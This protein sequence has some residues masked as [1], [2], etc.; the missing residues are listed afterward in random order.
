MR[1]K[2]R[3]TTKSKSSVENAPK[4]TDKPDEGINPERGYEDP[5]SEITRK[6]RRNLLIS[7]VGLVAMIWGSLVPTKIAAF[8]IDL[9]SSERYS[10]VAILFAVSCY[11]LTAF[12]FYARV[13][14][15]VWYLAL[16]DAESKMFRAYSRPPDES[17]YS[18]SLGG[19]SDLVPQYENLDPEVFFLA[20]KRSQNVY[21]HRRFFDIDFPI[22]LTFLV[23]VA[24]IIKLVWR[25][26]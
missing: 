13:D 6:E 5:L 23:W 4:Q 19:D 18:L 1:R 25:G 12:W 24:C 9:V 14:E 21:H 7:N 10:L 20:W 22:A 26:L 17:S 15:R 16:V 8:G 3:D 11:F 2:F